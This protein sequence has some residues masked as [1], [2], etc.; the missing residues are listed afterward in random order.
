MT[1]DRLGCNENR[2][3]PG[4]ATSPIPTPLNA[5]TR[6]NQAVIQRLILISLSR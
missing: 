4:L 6:R 5:E 1:N 3:V 2:F